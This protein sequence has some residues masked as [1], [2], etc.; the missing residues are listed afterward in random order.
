[1][2]ALVSGADSKVLTRK[3]SSQLP[4]RGRQRSCAIFASRHLSIHHCV[5]RH[6]QAGI[7]ALTA[8]AKQVAQQRTRTTWSRSPGFQPA[9]GRPVQIPSQVAAGPIGMSQRISKAYRSKDGMASL[10]R[11]Y[12][13]VNVQR[14]SEYSD[15]EALTVEWGD[16]DNYEVITAYIVGAVC[17]VTCGMNS[18]YLT[19]VR[20]HNIY[21]RSRNTV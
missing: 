19:H 18:G 6:I 10:A 8:F 1:M 2:Q 3:F 4:G 21:K 5:A 16:Q 20:K 11:V 12:R 13:D 17:A 9:S 15:Y 7:L 14:P